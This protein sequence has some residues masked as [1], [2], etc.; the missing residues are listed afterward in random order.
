MLLTPARHITMHEV[1][2]EARVTA[3]TAAAQA[4][5]D[6]PDELMKLYLNGC[7]TTPPKC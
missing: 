6:R 7:K 2:T 4:A 3:G 5:A 1:E